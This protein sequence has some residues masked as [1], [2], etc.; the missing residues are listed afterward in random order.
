[1]NAL[2]GYWNPWEAARSG[3]EVADSLEQARRRAQ[4]DQ[5]QDEIKAAYGEMGQGESLTGFEGVPGATRPKY[6]K[7]LFGKNPEAAMRMEQAMSAPFAMEREI[8]KLGRIE[9]AKKQADYDQQM[10]MLRAM[11]ELPEEAAPPMG[12]T[13]AAPTQANAFLNYLKGAPANAPEQTLPGMPPGPWRPPEAGN[14]NAMNTA[15]ESPRQNPAQL[16]TRERS[17]AMG[18]TGV[19]ITSKTPSPLD[20]AGKVADIESKQGGLEVQRGNLTRETAKD[21]NEAVHHIN[22]EIRQSKEMVRQIQRDIQENNIDPKSG[23]AQIRELTDGITSMQQR[24]DAILKGHSP[25]MQAQATETPT[26]P[27][28]RPAPSGMPAPT[29][30]PAQTA[31]P[32]QDTGLSRKQQLDLAQKNQTEKMTAANK[33]IAD[34]RAHAFSLKLAMPQIKELY[35]L[36]T[37][38]DMGA[39]VISNIPGGMGESALM[40]DKHYARLKNLGDIVGNT[41]VKPGQSQLM[42]TIVE[43]KM[44]TASTPNVGT[45]AQ[46]NKINAAVL[47]S[48]TQHLTQFPTFLEHWSQ[49]HGGTLDGATDAW[50]DYTDHNPYFTYQKDKHGKVTTQ[51]NRA[52]MPIEQWMSLKAQGRVKTLK[53]GRVLIQEPD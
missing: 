35:D 45:E 28:P 46:Q 37:T 51:E 50:T 3:Q 22:E 8:Q 24:R 10:K 48:N 1:M 9:A 44:M 15:M 12:L 33:E 43:R 23:Q 31:A 47:R 49:T 41:F 42:N 4:A 52:V 17:V 53:D 18:P 2:N 25:A 32:M 29:R 36:V 21:T 19:T 40:L 14:V 26:A 5:E 6:L 30:T 13:P 7:G 11:G 27:N 38:Q 20:S 39:P 34:A 16:S